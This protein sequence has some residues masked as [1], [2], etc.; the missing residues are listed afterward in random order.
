MPYC[1]DPQRPLGDEAR[2]VALDCL[3]DALERLERLAAGELDGVEAAVHEVR[4]RCKEVRGLLRLARPALGDDAYRAVNSDVRDAARQLS[5]LRD[6]H[7]L[8]ATIEELQGTLDPSEAARLDAVR[9]HQA[10]QVETATTGLGADDQ[11]IGVARARLTFARTMVEAW[12]LPDDLSTVERGMEQTHH[13]GRK[14]FR[15]AR[16]DPDDE[17]VHEWRKSVKQLWYQARLLEPADPERIGRM[18]ERLDALSDLLGDDHD[19][20]VLADQLRDPPT[21]LLSPDDVDHAVQLARARQADLRTQAFELGRRVY[22]KKPSKAVRRL[23]RPWADALA[24]RA[25]EEPHSTVERER[26]FLVADLPDLPDEGTAIRQGYLALDG[27]VAV[28]V[29]ERSGRGCAV[30]IKGGEGP[31]RTELEWEIP[32]GQFAAAWPLTDGRRIEKTRYLVPVEGAD[33]EVDV[34]GGAL[35]GLV[36]VEV[37]LP[38]DEALAAFEPPDWFGP[39]VTDDPRY[40]NAALAVDGLPTR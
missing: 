2:R 6:A 12:E 29:R 16:D 19:L 35:T 4:K 1:F 13:R 20:A 22:R 38:S 24:A 31:V 7:A 39:E 15:R 28:R 8:L 10:I 26:T 21:D 3:D 5:S 17:T 9:G 32:P 25:E 33:A 18:V 30:T 40:G 14:A 27:S 36:L 34:F 11:R 37:E 23:V